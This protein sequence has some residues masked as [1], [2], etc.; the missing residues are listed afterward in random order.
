MQE[1]SQKSTTKRYFCYFFYSFVRHFWDRFFV[2]SRVFGSILCEKW[3]TFCAF[4]W[5]FFALLGSFSGTLLSHVFA[6]RRT[7][8]AYSRSKLLV[9]GR[10]LM[11]FPNNLEAFFGSALWCFFVFFWRLFCSFFCDVCECFFRKFFVL[12]WYF[13]TISCCFWA[14]FLAVFWTILGR[15]ACPSVCHK[16]Q[17]HNCAR[18]A[19]IVQLRDFASHIASQNV[20]PSRG[21]AGVEPG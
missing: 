17:L 15:L 11:Q 20:S 5:C 21:R 10:F 19:K 1:I 3:A 16:P 8:D 9:A 13:F 6:P 14:A 4:F 18:I 7:S 2:F 12:F